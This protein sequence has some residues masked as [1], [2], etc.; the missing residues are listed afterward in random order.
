VAVLAAVCASMGSVSVALG[1]ARG[2]RWATRGGGAR[3]RREV[4][5]VRNRGGGSRCRSGRGRC[6]SGQRRP[7]LTV[8]KP[9]AELGGESG[10]LRCWTGE[11]ATEAGDGRR[12]VRERAARER[13]RS[14]KG[15]NERVGERPLRA[16]V[17]ARGV[18]GR[19]QPS[20]V[21]KLDLSF[22]TA[23]G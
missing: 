2:R 23:H 8:R 11:A 6:K 7:A 16:E 4:L 19:T 3:R 18:F 10:L 9:G 5:R 22:P 21:A 13:E 17:R 1:G 12:P 15:G 14:G 20:S